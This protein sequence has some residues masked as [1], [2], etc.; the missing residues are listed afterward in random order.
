MEPMCTLRE[1]S[2]YRHQTEI[3]FGC[4]DDIRQLWQDGHEAGL[5][6]S[7]VEEF[8]LPADSLPAM[9]ASDMAA[10]EYWVH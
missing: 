10:F 3:V 8:G 1:R 5:D 9:A 7:F 4:R 2:H 6:G